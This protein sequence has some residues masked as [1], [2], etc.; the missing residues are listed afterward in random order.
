[1]SD[2]HSFQH[3]AFG[4]TARS[5]QEQA[6]SRD[7]YARMDEMRPFLG[8]GPGEEAY[9]SERNSFYL[10]TVGENGWPYVQHRG[11]PPGVLR[12]L[13][14]HHLAFPD[15]R[16]NKQFISSANV[17]DGS[18]VSIILVDYHERQRLK[19]W[20]KATVI[21]A[22]DDPGLTAELTDPDYRADIERIF[23]LEVVAI[24]WNCPQHIK[25]PTP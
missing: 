19:I 5:M 2:V 17:R 6:G 18:P 15:Y 22:S 11:G 24:D 23:L 25:P 8:L 20:A 14:S 10:A 13:D 16:G 3:F 7:G 1:M 4:D 9:L 12:M 21:E